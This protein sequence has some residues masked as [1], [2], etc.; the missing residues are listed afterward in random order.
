MYTYAVPLKP[1]ELKLCSQTD[2]IT[3]NTHNVSSKIV[4]TENEGRLENN[5]QTSPSFKAEERLL[6]GI[7]GPEQCEKN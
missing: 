4:S 2:D 5:V 7:H 1:Q 3:G 6:A